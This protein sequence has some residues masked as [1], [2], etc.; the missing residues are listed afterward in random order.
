MPPARHPA[1]GSFRSDSGQNRTFCH[2]NRRLAPAAHLD[3]IVDL[4][5]SHL[6]F[7]LIFEGLQDKPTRFCTKP[8]R[9]LYGPADQ[10]GSDRRF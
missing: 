4:S 8:V 10:G 9:R 1:M 6:R 5:S 2:Q 3:R 7:R